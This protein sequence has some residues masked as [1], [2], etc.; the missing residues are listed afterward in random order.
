M[1]LRGISD[2]SLAQH[3]RDP[4]TRP[5]RVSE[6]DGQL[7]LRGAPGRRSA[8]GSRLLGLHREGL[9]EQEGGWRPSS[10]QRRRLYSR[11]RDASMVDLLNL[12][13]PAS[14]VDTKLVEQDTTS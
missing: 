10:T 11:E 5:L 3:A 14:L 6:S 12:I 7:V 2:G 1:R 4:P 9:W 8:S 13:D